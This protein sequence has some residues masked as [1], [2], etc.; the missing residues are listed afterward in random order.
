MPSASWVPG[1]LIKTR[2]GRLLPLSFLLVLSATF[3]EATAGDWPQ[4]LGPNRNGIAVDESIVDSFPDDGPKTVWQR[5]VGSG[6]AGL[7]VADGIAVLFHRVGDVERVEAMN[8]GT[9]EVLWKTDFPAEFVPRFV[10]DNGP[11]CVPL[12]HNGRVYLYGAM[13]GLHALDLKTGETLWSRDTFEEYKSQR[14]FRGEPPE[15]Y[16]GIGTSPIVLPHL[17]PGDSPGAKYGGGV[18][19]GINPRT[20]Q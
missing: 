3:S 13:G 6:F 4:I 19:G 16:F 8:A 18:T 2:L 9:G 10:N 1:F 15:G 20:A 12:I 11:R 7:A 5:E 14:S 17:A